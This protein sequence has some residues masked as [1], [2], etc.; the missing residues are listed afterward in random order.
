M[1][2]IL[3]RI[4]KDVGILIE[5]L[6]SIISIILFS[7]YGACIQVKDLIKDRAGREATVLANGPS[8]K[9]IIDNRMDLIENTDIIGMNKFG[10]SEVFFK[11]KPHYYIIIDPLFFFPEYMDT[12]S[13]TKQQNLAPIR[14]LQESFLKI[15]WDMI[16]FVPYMKNSKHAEEIYSRNPHVKIVH[17]NCTRITGF[18]WLQNWGYKMNLG[19]PSTYNV[20]IPAIQM[21]VNAGYKRIYLYGAE[22]SWTKLMDVDEETGMMYFNDNH[23]YSE[24]GDKRL[25]RRG[26]YSEVLYGLI[27]AIGGMEK[28][29]QYADY[30]GV[31]VV[32]RTKHSFIDCFEYENPDKL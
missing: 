21:M 16:L 14:K 19:V 9:D 5:S 20:T 1:K 10:S 12:K 4:Y 28:I 29:A 8:A 30:R 26:G 25:F 11:I 2:K 23:S 27:S 13:E 22:F 24:G 3:K 17:M 6:V 7:K 31:K 18:K 15:D 32:N